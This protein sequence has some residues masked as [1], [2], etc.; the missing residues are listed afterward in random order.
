VGLVGPLSVFDPVLSL[1]LDA[2]GPLAGFVLALAGLVASLSLFDRLFR[3]LEMARLRERYLTRLGH[4]GVSFLAGVVLTAL[5]TSVAFSLGVVVPLYNRGFVERAEILPF[6]LGASVGTLSDTLLAA[7]ALG[8]PEA[9]LV[10]VVLLA[11][12]TLLSLAVLAV[13]RPYARTLGRLH[14]RIVSDRAVFLAFVVSLV[15]VPLGL[16]A[17]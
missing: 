17:L 11:V 12:G 7:L 9:V 6:V 2:V 3:G 1:V 16:V 4:P 8:L 10:V 15:A 14:D 13:Y 5:T